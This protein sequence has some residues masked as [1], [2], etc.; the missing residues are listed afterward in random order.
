MN[1]HKFAA[2]LRRWADGM[3][4]PEVPVRRPCR[5]FDRVDRTTLLGRS[6]VEECVECGEIIRHD[7]RRA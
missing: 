6:R 2:F 7:K 3:D 1:R 4:P 5:H